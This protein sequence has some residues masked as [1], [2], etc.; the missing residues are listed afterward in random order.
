MF[1]D[2]EKLTGGTAFQSFKSNYLFAM[3]LWLI[4]QCMPAELAPFVGHQG[5]PSALIEC[6]CQPSWVEIKEPGKVVCRLLA[7]DL[8][9]GA[10]ILSMAAV[11]NH[12]I[13]PG[14]RQPKVCPIGHNTTVFNDHQLLG[15]KMIGIQTPRQ[16]TRH[17]AIGRSEFFTAHSHFRSASGCQHDQVAED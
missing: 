17:T 5:T 13:L 15:L 8:S 9:D 4:K 10:S 14:V 3:G 6:E 12:R 1:T 7:G 2:G 11:D 16:H